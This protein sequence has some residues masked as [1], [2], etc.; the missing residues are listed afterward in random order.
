MVRDRL[1]AYHGSRWVDQL[2]VSEITG[3]QSYPITAMTHDSVGYFWIA[4]KESV[5]KLSESGS[6]WKT[7]RKP[8]GLMG[9][10]RIY[11]DRKGRLW[12]GGDN[13]WLCLK[14]SGEGPWQTYNL[15]DFAPTNGKPDADP[16]RMSLG[17]NAIYQDKSGRLMFATRTGLAVLEESRGT[18]VWLTTD[19][20]GLPSDT[21]TAIGEDRVG[22][23][24]MGTANGLVVLEP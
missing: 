5:L 24:W 22:R 7:Y 20:S 10:S 17:V 1:F 2:K 19:N 16:A 21:V 11:E 4:T 8:A 9:I 6:P 14:G 13:G 18:W 15:A 3:V 12:F 23:I